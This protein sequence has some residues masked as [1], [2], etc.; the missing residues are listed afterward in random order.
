MNKR[1]QYLLDHPTASS[2]MKLM[3]KHEKANGKSALDFTR[4]EILVMYRDAKRSSTALKVYHTHLRG[5][6]IYETGS[7]RAYGEVTNA[8][9]RLCAKGKKEILTREEA[10][11][12]KHWLYNAIDKAVMELAWEGITGWHEVTSIR[13]ADITS[14]HTL[15]IVD[16]REI[17]LTDRLSRYLTE[18]FA[19]SSYT[20]YSEM[21]RVYDLLMMDGVYKAKSHARNPESDWAKKKWYTQII[22]TISEY[23]NVHLLAKDEFSAFDLRSYGMLEKLDQIMDR[24]HCDLFE[25]VCNSEEANAILVQYG[26]EVNYKA[27]Y[28]LY[29]TL[30]E[31]YEY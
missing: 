26:A 11:A 27:R 20:I 25:A 19:E 15:K 4:E 28:A 21:P 9:L 5:Y 17:H 24:N 7:M 13:Q 12:I 6:A 2:A 30:K 10:D 1:E 31:N 8:D 3:E 22:N 16:G 18:A 14:R 23:A 29:K